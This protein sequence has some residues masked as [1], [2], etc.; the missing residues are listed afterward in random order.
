MSLHKTDCN[1]MYLVALTPAWSR[2]QTLLLCTL[3]LKLHS[4]IDFL[5]T[6]VPSAIVLNTS[7]PRL[8]MIATLSH[9]MLDLIATF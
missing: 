6:V 1:L 2:L 7:A 3:M 8:D 9:L 5:D 4:I